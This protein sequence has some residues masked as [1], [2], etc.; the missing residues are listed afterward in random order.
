MDTEIIPTSTL[1]ADGKPNDNVEGVITAAEPNSI[2]GVSGRAD[3]S[4][5]I[6]LVSTTRWIMRSPR[7]PPLVHPLLFANPTPTPRK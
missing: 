2:G 7:S 4:A 3:A 1:V 6:T 5:V